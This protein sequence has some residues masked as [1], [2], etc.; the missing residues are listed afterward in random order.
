VGLLSR[1]LR[2]NTAAVSL[3]RLTQSV[4]QLVTVLLLAW[5]LMP[6]QYGITASV[7]AAL[8]I[9]VA[10]S[11]PGIVRQIQFLLASGHSPSEVRPLVARKYASTYA[12][13]VV[14]LLIILVVAAVL[15]DSWILSFAPMA[16]WVTTEQLTTTWN[17]VSVTQGESWR[18][19]PCYLL[20]RVPPFLALI[21]NAALDA[22]P[23]LVWSLAMS[24]GGVLAVIDGLRH[25]PAEFRSLN[26]RQTGPVVDTLLRSTSS[27]Q[28]GFLMSRIGD[29]LRDLDVVA[30]AAFSPTTAGSYGLATRF[31]RPLAMLPQAYSEANFPKLVRLPSLPKAFIGGFLLRGAILLVISCG[32]AVVVTPLLSLLV[33]HSY[34]GFVAAYLLVVASAFLYGATFMIVILMQSRGHQGTRV[35]GMIVLF[36]GVLQVAVVPA[37]GAPLGPVAAASAGLV[38][39]FLMVA[40][41]ALASTKLPRAADEQIR[42][43]APTAA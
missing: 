20:R 37:V 26:P 33:H 6:R 39:Y 12:G 32:G 31:L 34:D 16:L 21:A 7:N 2:N 24:F 19:I 3:A 8:G 1:V 15:R 17:A 41:L 4:L 42:T 22:E 9:L 10:L 18:L 13:S 35:S 11:A 23:V 36:Y 14:T 29:Q 5:Q 43:S 25:Q 28:R 40:T 38:C 27:Q 30:L